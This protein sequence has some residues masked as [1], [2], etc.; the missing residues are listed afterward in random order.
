MEMG[1]GPCIGDG[2]IWVGKWKPVGHSGCE[3]KASLSDRS[4]AAGTPRAPCN[5]FAISFLLLFYFCSYPRF[6]FP[7]NK[8]T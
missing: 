3:E 8:Q 2:Y 5:F 7:A 1:D 4:F 6:T